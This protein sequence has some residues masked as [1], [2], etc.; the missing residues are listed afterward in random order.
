MLAPALSASLIL[1]P[2]SCTAW[3]GQALRIMEEGGV[4]QSKLEDAVHDVR[5]P[6]K[7]TSRPVASPPLHRHNTTQH[8]RARTRNT[9]KHKIH[10]TTRHQLAR[11]QPVALPT[12][13]ALPPSSL[14]EVAGQEFP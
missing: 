10:K 14:K 8:T 4:D 5:G 7:V 12:L 6:N 1:I 11:R 2:N 13:G 9:Q 3:G